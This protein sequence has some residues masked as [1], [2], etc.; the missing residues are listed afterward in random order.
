MWGRLIDTQGQEIWRHF[1]GSTISALA[2]D[3]EEKRLAVGTYGGMLHF[4]ALDAPER[5]EYEIGTGAVREI[6][7]ILAW[8]NQDKLLWW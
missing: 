3:N 1:V 8:K 2:V 5:S 7:R 6:K 4:I